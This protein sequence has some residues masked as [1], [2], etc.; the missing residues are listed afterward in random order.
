MLLA[1]SAAPSSSDSSTIQQFIKRLDEIYR[2]T[3]NVMLIVKQLS[4][5]HAVVFFQMI[6]IVAFLDGVH[7]KDGF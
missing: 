4:H 7:L 6:E 2:G 1:S 5:F 3:S